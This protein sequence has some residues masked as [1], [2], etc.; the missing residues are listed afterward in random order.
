MKKNLKQIKSPKRELPF[1]GNPDAEWAEYIR[2]GNYIEEEVPDDELE[3]LIAD[4]LAEKIE[5]E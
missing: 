5:E 4:D 3:M 2:D 1:E